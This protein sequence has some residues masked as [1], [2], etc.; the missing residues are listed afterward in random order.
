M[1]DGISHLTLIVRDLEKTSRLLVDALGGQEVYSSG[2]ATF[3]HSREKFF[4]VGGAWIALME[5]EPHPG[6]SYDHIAFKVS[7]KELPRYRMAIEK[8]GLD[9]REPRPRIA[10]EGESLYFHD[11]DNHLFELHAGT[12]DERLAAYAK[13]DPGTGKAS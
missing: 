10:G 6:R 9:I 7:A 11:Y 8:L 1:V 12:L 5:G 3:S 4:I 13:T 2:D